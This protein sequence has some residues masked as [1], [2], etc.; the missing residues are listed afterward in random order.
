[1][2]VILILPYGIRKYIVFHIV[3]LLDFILAL[4]TGITLT[5]A[6]APLIENLT[7][8]PIILI[9]LVGV[10]VSGALHVMAID[11]ALRK[12]RKS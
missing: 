5:L 3:G 7:T 6:R 4:G 9:P 2:P 12:L 8:Y 11:V 10:P 1:V